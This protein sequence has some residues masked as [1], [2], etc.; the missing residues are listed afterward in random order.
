MSYMLD[1]ALRRDL[2]E[3]KAALTRHGIVIIRALETELE[4]A[5]MEEVR[6]SLESSPRKLAQIEEDDLDKFVEQLRRATE[7]PSEE[8]RALYTRLLAKLGTEDFQELA[9]ELE[10]ID[11]LF[12]WERVSKVA[13]LV[14]KLLGSKG[15]KPIALEGP[16]DVSDDF[17]LEFAERWSAAFARFKILVEKAVE[18][19]SHQEA[20]EESTESA[21]RTRK[22]KR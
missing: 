20:E 17:A 18:E 6:D 12:K 9:K 16:G 4:P 19:I 11:Q 7:R 14:N 21:V 22:K 1:P 2:T 8:L 13:E 3:A 5:I 15:F 10:G